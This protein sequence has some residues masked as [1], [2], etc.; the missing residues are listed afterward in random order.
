MCLARRQPPHAGG[1]GSPSNC[2]VP[3]K[4]V[5]DPPIIKAIRRHLPPARHR[6]MSYI[7]CGP[8]CYPMDIRSPQQIGNLLRL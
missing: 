4:D 6:Q 2:T 5:E 3:P 1:V 8:D 7:N